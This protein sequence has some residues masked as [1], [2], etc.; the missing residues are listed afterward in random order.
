MSLNKKY[1]NLPDLDLAPDVYETPDLTDGASTVPTATIRT[2]SD[3]DDES[4]PDIDRNNLNTDEARLHFLRASGVSAREVDFSDTI[5]T[6][7][8][9]YKSRSGHRR[10]RSV[11]GTE[12]IGDISD[13]DADG[14]ESFERK[15]ARLRRE[16]EE[17]K[18]ELQKRDQAGQKDGVED[19]ETEEEDDDYDGINELSKAL[20]SIHSSSTRADK[21]SDAI[22]SRKLAAAVNI[23]SKDTNTTTTEKKASP[24]TL[25]PTPS[26]SGLLEHAAS[27]DT[28]LTLMEAALGISS[29]SNPF[30]AAK[31]TQPQLQPVLPALEHLTSQITALTGTLS[32]P[33]ASSTAAP[34]TTTAQLESLSSRIKRLTADAENLANARRRA[35]EVAARAQPDS[36]S[37]DA[38]AS[39]SPSSGA[40]EVNNADPIARTQRDEQASKIQALYATIPTIQS[41]HPLLPS[42][43]ERLRSLRAIHAGAAQASETLDALEKDQAEMSKEIEQWREGL[44]VVEEKVRESEV[45]MRKNIEYVGPWVD[46]LKKRMDRLEKQF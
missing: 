21:T 4:N 32:R 18:A 43:L 17:L 1:A 13:S 25:T 15:L 37:G 27:F 3:S 10:R 40:T 36:P 33:T 11:G 20:D 8:K 34:A 6:K 7:R 9:A 12:E 46:D 35:S 29:G 26:S 38:F 39:A 22:L 2:N 23:S 30:F 42:V 19:E 16:T 41:L 31:D 44:R 45:S 14:Q 28:R 5:A 24:P